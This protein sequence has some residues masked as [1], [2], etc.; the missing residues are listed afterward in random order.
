MNLSLS[1]TSTKAPHF[2][3][4]VFE[5]QLH[6]PGAALNVTHFQLAGLRRRRRKKEKKAKKR[7]ERRRRGALPQ[8]VT[9]MAKNAFIKTAV[10]RR[11]S[12]SNISFF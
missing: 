12:L 4:A 6:P 10:L 8:D 9:E 3:K 11:I 2:L 7:G 1:L 5:G